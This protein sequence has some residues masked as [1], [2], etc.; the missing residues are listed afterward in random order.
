MIVR[1]GLTPLVYE[2]AASCP[3]TWSTHH[4]PVT[5]INL[6]EM[7]YIE[8]LEFQESM[9]KAG[10]LGT[11]KARCAHQTWARHYIKASR[12]AFSPAIGSPLMRRILS[13]MVLLVPADL[14]PAALLENKD[15]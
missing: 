1:W 2:L 15:P 13:G 3:I 5:N 8:A 14:G 7:D 12:V 10:D 9:P 11:E 6:I 4:F